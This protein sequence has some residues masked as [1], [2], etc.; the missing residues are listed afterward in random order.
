[1]LNTFTLAARQLYVSTISLD[2]CFQ[3]FEEKTCPKQILFL[4]EKLSIILDHSPSV[5]LRDVASFNLLLCFNYKVTFTI[6]F[7]LINAT[8][9]SE[10]TSETCQFLQSDTVFADGNTYL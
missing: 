5:E 3:S 1:M 7:L 2:N 8:A 9:P 10:L 6:L 4:P